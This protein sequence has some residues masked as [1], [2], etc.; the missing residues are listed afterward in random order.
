MLPIMRKHTLD[1]WWPWRVSMAGM[2]QHCPWHQ[3]QRHPLHRESALMQLCRV[4]QQSYPISVYLFQ[5]SKKPTYEFS[6]ATPST[7]SENIIRT[8][9]STWIDWNQCQVLRLFP[10]SFAKAIG[11]ETFLSHQGNLLERSARDSC[12]S[13]YKYKQLTICQYISREYRKCAPIKKQTV[14]FNLEPTYHYCDL[15]FGSWVN[16]I[17]FGWQWSQRV[18]VCTWNKYGEAE[19]SYSHVLSLLVRDK[20]VETHPPTKDVHRTTKCKPKRAFMEGILHHTSLDSWNCLQ[21]LSNHL[22]TAL[23]LD[24][25]K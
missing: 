6:Q 21:T 4:K 25:F 17:G 7:K 3:N 9:S 24:A 1:Q 11:Q 20:T 23:V 18:R 19:I 14:G 16:I 10:A 5:S 22:H 8:T 12:T 13:D 2:M 15:R